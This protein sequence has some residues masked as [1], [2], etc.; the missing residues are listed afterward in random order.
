MNGGNLD[1]DCAFLAVSGV[2]ERTELEFGPGPENRQTTPER[3]LS[4]FR[5]LTG[6][7]TSR[8]PLDAF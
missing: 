5:V 1:S 2:V 8:R 3:L 7:V 6:R 4:D